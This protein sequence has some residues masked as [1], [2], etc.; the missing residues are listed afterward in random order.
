MK[1]K[2]VE[3]KKI[4][5]APVAKKI[6]EGLDQKIKSGSGKM[7]KLI[8]IIKPK[9]VWETK[10]KTKRTIITH[11]GVK[12]IAD[13][14]G[15]SQDVQYT[16][17]TQPD[18]YNN[19]QY[20]IQ[21]RICRGKECTSEIGEANRNNLGAKGRQN[22]ANMA[23]K[24]AFDR[25]VLRLLGITGILSEE[26]LSD[27][28]DYSKE[29]NMDELTHEERRKIAPLINQLLLAKNKNDIATFSMKMKS[30][31]KKFAEHELAYVRKLY[32]KRLGELQKVSF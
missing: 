3:K 22:P 16:V 24:R 32:Q 23:Q 26:E 11:D 12:K 15:V 20:T 8:D 29:N 13:V 14:A 18:I 25:A 2:Q 19:Y 7:I 17:L 10:G 9:E 21:A 27:E 31:A 30:E 5:K 1:K 4:Q 6:P 28:E